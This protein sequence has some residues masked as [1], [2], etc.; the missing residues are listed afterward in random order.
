MLTQLFFGHHKN[1]SLHLSKT[2]EVA[3]VH[4]NALYYSRSHNQNNGYLL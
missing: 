4:E 2:Y 3:H 1:Q